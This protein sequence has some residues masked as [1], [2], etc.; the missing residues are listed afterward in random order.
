MPPETATRALEGPAPSAANAATSATRIALAPISG[1]NLAG[2]DVA[3]AVAGTAVVIGVL[4]SAVVLRDSV[5]VMMVVMVM[6]PVGDGARRRHCGDTESEQCKSCDQQAANPVNEH[7]EVPLSR[8]NS[9]WEVPQ[10]C[11]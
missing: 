4:I 8:C 3:I 9:A 7:R 6:S 5:A 2:L 11:K 10:C 1:T